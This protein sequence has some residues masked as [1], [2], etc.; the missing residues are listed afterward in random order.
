MT[1]RFLAP[2]LA[3]LL[4]ACAAVPPPTPG[5]SARACAAT[6]GRDPA[7]ARIRIAIDEAR[8]QHRLFG[9]QTIGPDGN[10][11]R[12][13]YHEGEWARPRGESVPAW[14]RVAQFWEAV[15]SAEALGVTTSAGRVPLAEAVADAAAEAG[16]AELAARES[17]LRAAMM[18][19]PWSAAFIS[20]L[21]KTAGFTPSEFAFSDSHA[22]YVRA[23][24]AASAAE[25]AGGEAGHAFRACDAATTPPRAGDLLCATRASTAGTVEFAA[26]RDAM[27]ARPAGF[28]MHCDLVVRADEGGD[29]ALETIGGNVVNSVTLSRMRLDASKVLSDAYL[30]GAGPRRDCATDEP[31]CRDHF[32]RR[33]WLVLLQF[34][35]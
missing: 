23:A 33:P 12:V 13:G 18:D 19:T 22:D 29:G 1:L 3:A 4:G 2:L 11:L 9:H 17:T 26:L 24:L 21:M 16:P 6:A 27:D 34:R 31:Q 30:A 28:P 10:L 35:R 32:S 20:H 25:A 7:D 8:R 15:P 5:A 14:Q